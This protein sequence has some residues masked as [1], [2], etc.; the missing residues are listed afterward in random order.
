MTTPTTQERLAQRRA[1]LGATSKPLRPVEIETPLID[2]F[3]PAK[4]ESKTDAPVY[5]AGALVKPLTGFYETIGGFILLVDQECGQA[6][7][8]CANAA[9]VS[10]DE[11]ARVNPKVRKVLMKL[12][13]SSAV[14]KV[15]IAHFPIIL[16]VLAHHFPN[17]L[18]YA[19]TIIQGGMRTDE[20]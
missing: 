12:M 17:A 9:A 15:T 14:T 13:G 7:I 18:K 2:A 11:L 5:R 20:K 19:L 6:I 3:P 8:E 1:D 10:L 4:T 16:A